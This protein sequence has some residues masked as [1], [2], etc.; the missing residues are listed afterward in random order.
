VVRMAVTAAQDDLKDCVGR[1]QE[2]ERVR[3]LWTDLQTEL[4]L[5]RPE[6]SA[7]LLLE[8]STARNTGGVK[9]ASAI[10]GLQDRC[11]SGCH[12]RQS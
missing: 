4:F 8:R 12:S 3:V 6:R 5:R 9:R 7:K 10:Y 2:C 1:G 11:G